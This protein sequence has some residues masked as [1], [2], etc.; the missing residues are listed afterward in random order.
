MQSAFQ[1]NKICIDHISFSSLFHLGNLY[2]TMSFTGTL[3]LLQTVL[4]CWTFSANKTY[5][6]DPW[7]LVKLMV[8]AKK[9]KTNTFIAPMQS[10][11]YT[12]L[13]GA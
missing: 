3:T 11:K 7:I 9:Q 4:L 10:M 8:P 13:N 2:R 6:R 12:F 5:L 1:M